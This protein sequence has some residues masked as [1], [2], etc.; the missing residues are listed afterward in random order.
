MYFFVLCVGK[1]MGVRNVDDDDGMM[2]SRRRRR[3]RSKWGKGAEE[4]G[5]CGSI[6]TAGLFLRPQ[7]LYFHASH[8]FDQ[9]GFPMA[10]GQ[11]FAARPHH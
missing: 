4:R 7:N 3:K 5:G 6:P 11:R 2:D 9:S 1:P 8:P 10:N